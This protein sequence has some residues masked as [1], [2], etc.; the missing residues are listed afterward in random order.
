MNKKIDDIKFESTNDEMVL[1]DFVLRSEPEAID[2]A[3]IMQKTY[4]KVSVERRHLRKRHLLRV[5]AVVVP[6]LLC[7]LWSGIVWMERAQKPVQQVAEQLP[8]MRQIVVGRN[9]TLHVTL[10][11]GSRVIAN[12]RTELSYP[13]VFRGHTRDVSIKGEG[14]FEVVHNAKRPFII[15]TDNFDVKVLGTKFSVDNYDSHAAG[16]TLLEGLVEVETRNNDRVRIHPNERLNISGEQF[17]SREQVSPAD[18]FAHLQ[19]ILHLN[20]N[21]LGDVASRLTHYFGQKIVVDGSLQ[22]QRLYGKLI[23]RDSI[24]TVISN[25]ATIADARMQVG[26]HQIHLKRRAES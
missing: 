1:E 7:A 13:S 18:Y 17:V 21:E 20:G 9:D 3:N 22:H 12:S 11:D 6:L 24:A 26:A 2:V 15:H 14:Y 5:A 8:V 19:G 16:V 25:L 23:I 10:P 4:A